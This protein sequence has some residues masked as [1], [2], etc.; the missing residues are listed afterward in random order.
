MI[1]TSLQ[2][3]H[4]NDVYRVTPQK[5]SNNKEGPNTIDVTQFAALVDDL[6]DQWSVRA[7]GKRDGLFLFS[8][9]VFSPSVESSVTRGSHMVPVLNQLGLDVSLTGNHDFDFGYPHLSKLIKDTAFPW[10]LSNIIDKTTGHVPSALKEYVVF[11]RSGVKIGVIGLVEEEWIATVSSWPPDFVYKPMHEV[12]IDLS[13]RLRDPASEEQCDVIIALTHARLPND[14]KLAKQ[15]FALSSAAQAT[16]EEPFAN[17]HGVDLLLGGHDHLYFVPR[18]VDGWENYDKT[19]PVLGAE[20]DNGDVLIVKSGSDF[21][22]VSAITLELQASP[23]GSVRRRTIKSITGKRHVTQPGSKSSETM[24]ELLKKLLSSVTDALSAPVCK[25]SVTIDVR[26][27]Y[28][29]VQESPVA[30]WISD[31]AR[32][33]YDESLRSQGRD[34]ADGVLFCAG[35][36]RG[37]STYAPGVITIGNILDI[38]PFEDPVVAI[39]IDGETLWDALESSLKTW[40]AQEGRFPAISGFRVSWDSRKE[41][42]NRVLGIWLLKAGDESCEEEPVERKKDGI[43][44]TVITRD[45][46]AQGHDGF[47][48]LK[49]G[50]YVID[51]DCGELMSAIVRKYLLGSQFVNR[52]IRLADEN[53]DYDGVQQNTKVAI[54]QLQQNMDEKRAEEANFPASAWKRAISATIRRAR[55]HLHYQHHLHISTTEHMSDVDAYDGENARLGQDCASVSREENEDLLVVSPAIDGRLKNEGAIAN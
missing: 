23:E 8:G 44:Y 40:P 48:A 29:R 55:E 45:Y 33:A 3:L 47:I 5:I 13:K 54:S 17:I 37:D 41:P 7:D 25:T 30:N 21:H 53:V 38:L 10:I 19:T 18:G 11:E 12:A 27:A 16:C 2:V 52:F 43:T 46:M 9:D 31:I 15:A 51:H 28:I 39:E 1:T 32:H 35:T 20:D 6:R 4:F 24:S 34:G 36:F 22:D 50:K 49:N 26:S 42:G 14:I